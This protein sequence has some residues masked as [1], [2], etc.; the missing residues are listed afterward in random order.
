MVPFDRD[1]AAAQVVAVPVGMLGAE[2]P[3]A[4]RRRGG[5]AATRRADGLPGA[6]RTCSS[7][8]G[9][10]GPRPRCRRW[11]GSAHSSA[12]RR[13]RLHRDRARPGTGTQ[14]S[15]PRWVSTDVLTD[16]EQLR[17]LASARPFDV[18]IDC[19]GGVAT[20][21]GIEVTRRAAASCR[22]SSLLPRVLSR[23][24]CGVCSSS[25]SRTPSRWSWWRPW[26]RR[27]GLRVPVAATYPV[28]EGARAYASQKEQP[29]RPGKTV[30]E[31]LPG[32]EPH[33]LRSVRSSRSSRSTRVG[34]GP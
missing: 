6:R 8:R 2:A 21:L 26:P 12:A 27:V 32:A 19:V 17:R 14:A 18:V 13:S 1:G 5:G 34:E 23:W 9:R 29:R 7:V 33:Q 4:G 15:S 16:P 30:A 3:E 20:D 24:G 22:S 10:R 25:S 28:A 11:R 31:A